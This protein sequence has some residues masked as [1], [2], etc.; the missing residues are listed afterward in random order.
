MFERN[1]EDPNG[2]LSDEHLR[3]LLGHVGKDIREA[4]ADVERKVRA[5][6]DDAR[7]HDAAEEV[8]SF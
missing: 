5:T 6:I 7:A 8:Q 2:E 3:E 1:L 4:Q